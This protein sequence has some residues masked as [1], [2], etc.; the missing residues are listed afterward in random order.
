MHEQPIQKYES[1]ESREDGKKSDEQLIGEFI[2]G[3]SQKC[4]RLSVPGKPKK[5]CAD[6]MLIAELIRGSDR[7]GNGEVGVFIGKVDIMINDHR[8]DP[9]VIE[10]AVPE[11]GFL[12]EKRMR[13]ERKDIKEEDTKEPSGEIHSVI[14]LYY[15][16]V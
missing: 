10:D 2:A 4:P 13:E 1:G 16:N 8:S 3:S 12:K 15:S 11:D 6:G 5:R 7:C 9:R 14:R